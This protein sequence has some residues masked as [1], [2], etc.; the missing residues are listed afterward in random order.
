MDE[1]VFDAVRNAHEHAWKKASPNF[2]GKNLTLFLNCL[3]SCMEGKMKPEDAAKKVGPKIS[4][5]VFSYAGD[6]VGIIL[7]DCIRNNEND[8]VKNAAKLKL[9][10]AMS[11]AVKKVGPVIFRYLKGD[12][13]EEELAKQLVKVAKPIAGKIYKYVRDTGIDEFTAKTG[14]TISPENVVAIEKYLKKAP[15]AAALSVGQAQ[16]LISVVVGI[17]GIAVLA[18][19]YKYTSSVLRDADL[20]HEERL[21]IEA[22]CAEAV[23]SICRYRLDLEEKVS[24]YLSEHIEAFNE[25][26]AEMDQALLSGDSDGFIA[27]NVRIQEML[28]RKIQFRNQA[29]FDE[30][31]LSDEAFK[32]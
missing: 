5:G 19:V 13:K 28:G 10:D 8:L 16:L 14:I 3:I 31:M 29:E 30:L 6:F 15:V 26:F 18:E 32:L 25:G 9:G 17:M 12:I 27:G 4:N 21:R 24:V 20:A 2:E 11:G 1:K 23:D 7:D 22:E